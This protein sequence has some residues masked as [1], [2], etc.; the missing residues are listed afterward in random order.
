M[1][2]RCAPP[3]LACWRPAAM[4]TPTAQHPAPSQR[5]QIESPT[6]PNRSGIRG[7][8][9]AWREPGQ[10]QDEP[11]PTRGPRAGLVC[12]P[13]SVRGRQG[14][15]ADEPR[16]HPC[17]TPHGRAR[18]EAP[19][20]A[21]LREMVCPPVAEATSHIVTRGLPLRRIAHPGVAKR[22]FSQS[23]HTLPHNR[24]EAWRKYDCFRD[25]PS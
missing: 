16:W 23:Q 1:I 24:R 11:V 9:N 13:P 8:S 25:W 19:G 4:A 7:G 12:Q 2:P 20:A 21:G 18:D 14:L 15:G 3:K 17:R 5:R 6:T 10:E 22:A